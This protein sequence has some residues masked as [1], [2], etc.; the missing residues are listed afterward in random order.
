[1]YAKS[2][3]VINAS[4]LHA[5]P[6]SDFISCASKFKSRV[7]IGRTIDDKRIN[8]KSIVMLLTLA[9]TKGEEIEII[10]EGEDE[11]EAVDAL[12]ALVDAGINE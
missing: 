6:A 10:A 3:V 2:T 4:G 5:R 11:A 12:V 1:M 8:A 9:I 7:K